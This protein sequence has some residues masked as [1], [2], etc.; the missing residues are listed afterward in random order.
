MGVDALKKRIQAARKE[1][2]SD[3]VLKGCRV[4]DVFS[5]TIQSG[6]VAIADS[7][8]VGI[9][10]GYQGHEVLKLDGRWVAPGLIEAHMHIESSMM[11][12]SRLAQALLCRGTTAAISDPHEIAN[13]M[14]IAGILLML[15]DSESIPFDFYFMAPSCVP[16]TPLESSGARL[17][18]STLDRLKAIPRVL[19]LAEV[20]NY[21]GVLNGE[22]EVL[23]KL[24]LFGD[25]IIDGHA[26]GLK[27]DDLQAYVVAGIRSDHET[28]GIQEGLEKLRS[29]MMIMIREGSSAKN[30]EELLPLVTTTNS[31]RFCLVSDD[32]HPMD[33]FR[34]GHLDYIVRRAISLGLDPV[35]AI[36]MTTLNPAEYFGLKGRGAVAPGYRA[37]LVVIDDL[38]GF[39]AEKVFKDGDLVANNGEVIW[40]PKDAL[41]GFRPAKLNIAGNLSPEDFRIRSEG[42]K[43][44]VIEVIPNQILTDVSVEAVMS[45]D[46]W[47]LTDTD[48]DILKLAV[49]ERHVATGRIGLGMVRGFGLRSGAIC[50]SISHDSHNLVVLGTNDRDMCRAVFEVRDMGGG[51]AVVEDMRVIARMRLE[52][53]GLMSREPL[54]SL[55]RELDHVKKGAVS[56]GCK[57]SDPFMVLSFL[58]LPVIPKLKLTDMGLVDAE[59][60]RLVPLFLEDN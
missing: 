4:V 23:E 1:I 19:G 55:V 11:L 40:R 32:L 12:P 53:G 58:A 5:G 50:S 46:G 24:L 14:G 42:K 6:D 37:D 29:G 44:R 3:V 26:P 27:G 22:K 49:V 43:I 33:L 25:K 8:I 36:Q 41:P 9:G 18:V 57:L 59:E 56:L 60:F 16:A 38:T 21:A 35:T 2:P 39:R 30:L 31:R 13:V 45:K 10:E 54:D 51:I 48:R 47:V 20:M 17:E 15:K 28:Y 34:R 52:I 7:H